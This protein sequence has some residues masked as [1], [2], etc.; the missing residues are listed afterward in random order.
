V[1]IDPTV[2]RPAP[3]V[4]LPAAA[5]VLAAWAPFFV[6]WSLFILSYADGDILLAVSSGLVNTGAAALLSL[7]VWSL[8]AR[9][10]WPERMELPFYLLHIAAG[11]AYAVVWVSFSIPAAA[12]LTGISLAD[13]I[14]DVR[15]LF[16][17]IFMGLW[18]Y[19]C[20]AGVAYALRN[21]EQLMKEERR[22]LEARTL[23]ARATLQALRARLDP[24]FLFNALHTI[25]ALI[26]RDAA[27]A[28]DAVDR[29]GEL[30]R[31]LLEQGDA[32]FAPLRDEWRFTQG[33]LEL[34]SLRWERPPRI[35]ADLQPEALDAL[36]PPLTLQPLVENALRHGRLEEVDAPEIRI[37][38]SKDK[39][40]LRIDVEDNGAGAEAA[41][42]LTGV[43][44]GLTVLERRLAEIYDDAEMSVTTAV[45]RGFKVSLRLPA[46]PA[47]KLELRGGPPE[48]ASA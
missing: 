40:A 36:A 45:G 2:V 9:L 22:T 43:G 34:E 46:Q 26:P 44:H 30:L 20:V 15:N 11:S 14:G 42:G 23:A 41:D 12:A 38:A 4:K 6:L 28:E 7:A 29:L 10:P 39:G 3:I 1:T 47:S 5:K 37:T 16:W 8:T 18:I 17:R 25:A 27:R 31:Y 24:H 35:I 19:G 48:G 33:Y 21:R 32:A 13:A